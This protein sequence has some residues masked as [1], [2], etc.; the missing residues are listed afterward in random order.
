[1]ITIGF[2]TRE[3]DNRIYKEYIQKTCMYKEVEIIAKLNN[4][5]KSLSEVYN[6]II[7][8]SSNEIVVLLHDDLEFD[9]KNWGEKLIKVFEKNPEYSIVG[10]A[11]TK[12]LEKSARWWTVPSTMFGIVNHKHEGKKWTSTYSSDLGNKVEETILVDG[13]FIAFNKNK[14]K[15][16]FDTSIQGFHFYDL[17][18]CLPNYLDGV[19]IGVTTQIRVT[20]LSIGQTNEQWEKN[21]QL[22]SEKY[23]RVLPIDILKKDYSQTFIFC[24]N[25]DIIL[26]FEEHGKFKN[27]YNYTYVFLGNKDVNKLSN[28]NNVIIARELP[29]N[30]EQYP[31]FTSFTGWYALWKNNLIKSDYINLFEYDI[32]LNQNIE[33]NLVRLYENKID[34]LGYVPFGMNNYH[35]INNPRWV[36]DIHMGIKKVY[37]QDILGFFKKIISKNPN[38]IWSSTSNTTFKQN[39]FH[40]YMKWFEPLIPFLIDSETSGHAH[41]RSIT[42]FAY[43]RNKKIMIL[44]GLLKHF[45]MNSHMT[46]EHKIDVENYLNKLYKNIID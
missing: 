43:L 12:Y 27:L 11:G 32:I 17:G 26:G 10:L 7:E 13:L 2:S 41:E 31:K 4:G 20:H 40:D 33:Q 34:M 6:E 24:H 46:Q 15:H 39:V 37:N 23:D 38:S 22:F 5:E 18:F 3:K 19:K 45:Q 28:L 16:K 8:E 21:R 42:F 35:F 30:L 14:I 25:Q 29:F 1:M 9:T 44:N 36:E